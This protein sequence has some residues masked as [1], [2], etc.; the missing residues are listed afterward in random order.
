M[1]HGTAKT[2]AVDMMMLNRLQK[3]GKKD[4]PVSLLPE[5]PNYRVD[6]EQQQQ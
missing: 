2:C 1:V 4:G 6:Q 3:K 5:Q